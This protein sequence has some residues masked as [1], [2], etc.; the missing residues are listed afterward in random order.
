MTKQRQQSGAES[1][2][3]TKQQSGTEPRSTTMQQSE[4]EPRSTT[5][6]SATETADLDVV[7]V[8]GVP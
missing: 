5:K 4:A 8:Q 7:K 6:S 1:R 3:T 2:S